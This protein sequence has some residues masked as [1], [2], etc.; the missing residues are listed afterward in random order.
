MDPFGDLTQ[1]ASSSYGPYKLQPTSECQEAFVN[2]WMNA[3]ALIVTDIDVMMLV[4]FFLNIA[5]NKARPSS[6]L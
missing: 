4:L 2:H 3:T 1:S 5:N 6:N